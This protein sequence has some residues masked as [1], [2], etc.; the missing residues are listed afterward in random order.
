VDVQAKRKKKTRK[1]SQEKAGLSKKGQRFGGGGT[2]KEAWTPRCD[3]PGI[4][5]KREKVHGVPTGRN[6][7]PESKKKRKKRDW[8][9]AKKLP[10]EGTSDRRQGRLSTSEKKWRKQT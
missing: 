2:T 1:E 5:V 3:R 6:G 4:R 8:M 10:P 7:K 9:L